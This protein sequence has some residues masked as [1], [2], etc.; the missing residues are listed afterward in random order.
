MKDILHKQLKLL[1]S[2]SNFS[3]FLF[4]SCVKKIVYDLHFDL[5]C[6]QSRCHYLEGGCLSSP[7]W[8]SLLVAELHYP[9]AVLAAPSGGPGNGKP[10]PPISS[11]ATTPPP[12]QDFQVR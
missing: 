10:R 6:M 9:R 8:A 12:V 11:S 7:R 4:K 3:F 2:Y 5:R 1:G